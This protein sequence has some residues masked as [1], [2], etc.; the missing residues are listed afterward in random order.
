MPHRNTQ[1][2]V[3]GVYCWDVFAESPVRWTH[4]STWP[5]FVYLWLVLILAG[6]IKPVWRWTKRR[7]ANRWSPAIGRIESVDVDQPKR[8]FVST[9]LTRRS[10]VHVA[11]LGYSYSV[12]GNV[13]SGRYE[14]EFWTEEEAW[15][16]VRDLKDKAVT[17]QYNPNKPSTSTL[18][19]S[20][21]ETLL[22]S[23]APVSAAE[24]FPAVCA[25]SVPGRLKPF[26]GMFTGLSA[27]GLAVSLWV[28]L[29]AV[30]GRRVAP[31]AFFW[32]L[33]LG[34]FVVWVPVVFV[35]KRRVGNMNRK[36][37]WKAVLKGS[38]EWMRYMVYLFLGYATVNFALFFIKV[39]GGSG[40]GAN[41][42]AIVWRGFSG[43]WMAFYSAA[44]AVLYS[45]MHSDGSG[46]QCV[47]GHAVSPGA[48]YCDRCGQ[49]VIRV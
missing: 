10:S 28:H 7:R 44:L 14:R 12:A 26:L 17:V 24:T 3:F 23:R 49:P 11:L 21:I 48:R 43:H 29:G 19:V 4:P 36:D 18:V 34:I 32:I 45:A 8:S 5:W 30:M 35:A 41:P 2:N 47:N 16:F 31:E 42:P 37:F 25:A 9:A 33:H 1:A 22:R 13:Y 40:G 46:S 15:E 27:I 20:A 6:W 38:P 39:Q